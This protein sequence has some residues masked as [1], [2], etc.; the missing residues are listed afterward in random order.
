[1]GLIF[2]LDELHATGW[3]CLDTTGCAFDT[4]G[5]AYPTI[6][7]VQ[8]EF[9]AAGF[10]FSITHQSRFNCYRAEWREAGSDQTQAVV[11][12]SEAEAAVYALA[13]FRRSL[14]AA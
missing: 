9:A 13:Q 5:R 3:S 10:E 8:Q 11:G 12:H 7:R 6:A 4:D 2:A 14:V 1:M